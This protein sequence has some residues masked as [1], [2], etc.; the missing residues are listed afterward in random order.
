M[1]KIL[2]IF[3]TLITVLFVSLLVLNNNYD[4]PVEEPPVQ[5]LEEYNF[6][7]NDYALFSAVVDRYLS[8]IRYKYNLTL[9]QLLVE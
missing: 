6:I 4:V 3:I 2:V 1:K 9:E 5:V 8:R 7:F